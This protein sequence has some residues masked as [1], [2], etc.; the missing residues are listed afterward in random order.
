VGGSGIPDAVSRSPEINKKVSVPSPIDGSICALHSSKK[1]IIPLSSFAWRIIISRVWVHHRRWSEHLHCRDEAF[2]PHISNAEHDGRLSPW[3]LIIGP[4][5]NM[6]ALKSAFA[7]PYHDA[8]MRSA[9]NAQ[10]RFP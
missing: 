3:G 2:Y 1:S 9:S 7:A 6:S 8:A 5:I 4:D 10:E